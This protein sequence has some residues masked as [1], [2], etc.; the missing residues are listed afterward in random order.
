MLE[1]KEQI[2]SRK[3]HKTIKWI[4]LNSVDELDNKVEWVQERTSRTEDK[5]IEITQSEQQKKIDWKKI[6]RA[7][8]THG[9]KTKELKFIQLE[10]QEIKGQC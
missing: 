7:L 3:K 8:G 2:T 6:N 9:T 4:F 10:S 5:T 1:T